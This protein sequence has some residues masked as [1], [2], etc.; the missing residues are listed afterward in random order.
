MSRRPPSCYRSVALVLLVAGIAF[1][2]RLGAAQLWDRD[3]PRN[4]RC[5]CEMLAS[6][7]WV[8]PTFN[9]E[10]RT[11]KPILLYWLMMSAYRVFGVN[12]FA[13]RFWSAGLAVGTVLLTYALGQ[14]LFGRATATWAGIVLAT[15]LMFNVAAHAAT[16]DSALIFCSTLALV[17]FAYGVPREEWTPASAESPI[18][19]SAAGPLRWPWAVAA[20]S[21]LGLGVLAKGPIGLLLPLAV[22]SSFRWWSTADRVGEPARRPE[23][24]SRG[25]ATAAA[26]G[27]AL[28][29]RLHPTHLARGVW[30]LRPLTGVLLVLAVAAPWY[31]WVGIRT[32]GQWLREFLIEHNVGRALRP[33]EG[34][35]GPTALYYPVAILIGFF[36]WTAFT[37]PGLLWLRAQ[38]LANGF[39][40]SFHLLLAWI[41]IY[42]VAFSLASTKLPSYVTPTYPALALLCG[43]FLSTW[44]V[45]GA[46]AA[47]WWPRWSAA[48]LVLVGLVISISLPLAAHRFLPGEERLGLIG[49]TLCL[50]GLG[51]AHGFFQTDWQV[52]MRW[53]AA[54]SLLFVLGLFAWVG[55]RVS[56]H[57]RIQELLALAFANGESREVA[58]FGIHE[59]S[60]VFYAGQQLPELPG[61][62]PRVALDW[63]QRDQGR[64]ITTST[65]YAQLR[66]VLPSQ[67]TVLGRIPYFLKDEQLLLLGCASPLTVRDQPPDRRR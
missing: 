16:P 67:V 4:A 57:Q 11:H 30:E 45:T 55:P 25:R 18:A 21:A 13:A 34:H 61:N 52:G 22:W 58:S 26:I 44:P 2:T 50:G 41:G 7:D 5:A 33:M 63:L 56:E 28:R 24:G 19:R 14:R 17:C 60:W 53:F 43:H 12:E 20:Y 40:R 66:A 35:R 36:P 15:S 27:A 48:T 62:A 51:A 37:I 1:F 42:V 8:V 65:H 29:P 39:P 31:L 47:R 23:G 38:R 9:G 64:L 10:L 59:P 49:V 32:D 6:G 3:E 46:G 54:T